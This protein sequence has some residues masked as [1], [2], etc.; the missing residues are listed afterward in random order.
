MKAFYNTMKIEEFA[1]PPDCSVCRATCE[2]REHSILNGCSGIKPVHLPEVDV[3]TAIACN[4]CGEPACED[5]CPTG[6][7]TKGPD[8]GIVRINQDKCLGCGL[9]SLVCPYGGIDYNAATKHSFK[10]DLCNGNPQ[11]ADACPN[12][13]ISFMKSRDVIKYFNN[14]QFAMGS[15]LCLGCPAELSLRFTMKILGKNTVLFGAPG[16]AV[17]L[18][19]GMGTK[20]YCKVPTH[21]TNMTNLPS[22]AAGFKKYHQKKGN[23][24]QCVCFAGDGC[25][26]DVGFQALSGAAER[27]DNLITICYDNEGYMNTGV[28][29]SGTTPYLSWTTTTPVGTRK[30]GKQMPPK[31][32]PLIMAAHDIPYVATATIGFPEDY[33]KK[34]KKAMATKDGLSYI[35]LFT[36]CPTGWRAPPE[37]GIDICRLA[38]ET[39]S[40]PLWEYERGVYQFTHN[41]RNQKPV[42]EYL[43][44]MRKYNHLQ[45]ADIEEIQ[46]KVYE[47]FAVIQALTEMKKVKKSVVP[48]R[49]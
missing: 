38:V 47:R 8:D 24:V 6:A 28:Q 34:L 20:T 33:A 43:R 27:G 15:P 32:M 14:D 11:C 42:S 45:E 18:I 12:D 37:S 23:D 7:I 35:H 30:K 17:L 49:H 10:C 29:R 41:V 19:C 39:N 25:F 40:F 4:Q 46:Q 2:N 3:H 36:P 22:T 21:M 31:N 48:S 1:C 26:A 5:H 16:C 9:C 13:L 44:L